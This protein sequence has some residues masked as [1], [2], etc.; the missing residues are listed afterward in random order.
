MSR[1]KSRYERRKQKRDKKRNE[2]K[3]KYDNFENIC[4]LKSLYKSA[5]RASRGVFWKASVQR[6]ML[7]ILFRIQ[8]TRKDLQAGKDIRQGFIEFDLSDRGKPRHIRSVHFPERVVQKSICLNALY[9]VLT[10]D[11][12]YDNSA[13]QIDKGTLFATKRLAKQLRWHYKHF[14]RGGW[15]LLVD[16]KSYF[17]NIDH[18]S[19]KRNLRKHFSDEKLLK[20]ADDFVDAFGEK[21]LGLGSETS[22]IN[23]V[24]HITEIDHY[25][26]DVERVKCYG[27]YMDDSYLIC[28]DK[29]KLK[30]IFEVLK[31]K[32]AEFGITINQKKTRIVP[33]KQGFEYLKTRF[34]I[35]ENG[36][37]VQ[38]PCRCSITRE[39]RKLKRQ[40]KLVGQNIISTNEID[41]SFASFCGSMKYR[42]AR[43]SVYN[44]KLLKERLQNEYCG[45]H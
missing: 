8:K 15:V 14:G 39:R 20:L 11:V 42:D 38:K 7:S 16:F 37:I 1:R 21:G 31:K 30:R 10:N 33:L 32:Y 45:K 4:S 13:S 27:R 22:Q 19:I 9:P 40:F 25:I 43:K 23:A 28:E 41:I 6:Y 26:K 44:M 36:K 35:T 29:E 17:D 34:Y 3:S 18:A 5:Q 12:I 24:A 2:L